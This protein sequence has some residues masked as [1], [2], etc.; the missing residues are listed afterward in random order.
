L[1]RLTWQIP[2]LRL[3]EVDFSNGPSAEVGVNDL[4]VEVMGYKLFICGVEAKSRRQIHVIVL[5]RK[6]RKVFHVKKKDL[7]E[8]DKGKV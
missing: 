8:D 3:V 5:F 7:E 4:V 1:F 6:Q 2:R